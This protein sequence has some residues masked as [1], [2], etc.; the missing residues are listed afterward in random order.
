M[1]GVVGGAGREKAQDTHQVAACKGS[2]CA[3]SRS[4]Q[5]VDGRWERNTDV[6]G[7]N[8]KAQVQ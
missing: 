6:V 5:V 1:L 3:P 2:F 8:G 7:F 4:A